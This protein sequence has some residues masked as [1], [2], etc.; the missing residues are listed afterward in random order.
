MDPFSF[1]KTTDV[2][3]AIEAVANRPRAT[4]IGG[5]TA[6]LDLMKDYVERHDCLVDINRLPFST[7]ETTD[8]GV[9][10]GALVRNS[11]MAEHPIIQERYPAL[12][13]TILYAA[14]PQIRNKATVGGNLM[15]R[16][17]CSYFRDPAFPCNKRIPGSG[18]PAISGINRGHALLG[19][20]EQCIASHP[21]SMAVALVAFDA[22]LNTRSPTGTR[23]IPLTEFYRLPGDTPQLE[24]V[25]QP[26]E[27]II[28]VELPAKPYF[29]HSAHA[30]VR[31]RKLYSNATVVAA[32]NVENDTIQEARIALGGV[33][34]VPW[35]AYQA[36]A[37]L[38]GRNANGDAFAAAA[39]A[40]VEG[41]Q[42]TE[43]NQFKVELTKRLVVRAL[44]LSRGNQ[45][46]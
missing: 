23:R 36:E 6:L 41:M 32:L 4:F 27:M 15:Q 7:I 44:R 10:I 29:A 14:L 13:E 34:T 17:R 8:S 35:R 2:S 18:C 9:R 12:S 40:A 25:L 20:S 39:E 45:P 5:G 28:S 11:Q 46:A 43:Y 22:V 16:T 3:E 37:T 24:T 31:D 33:A 26:G 1:V 42:P 30:K 19:V 38:Q 21:S